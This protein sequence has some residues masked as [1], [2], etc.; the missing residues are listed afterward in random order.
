MLCSSFR[1]RCKCKYLF[2]GMFLRFTRQ[3]NCS[4]RWDWNVPRTNTGR[5]TLDFTVVARTQTF[6][7][8]VLVSDKTVVHAAAFQR[9]IE[10]TKLEFS[11]SQLGL[12]FTYSHLLINLR[13]EFSTQYCEVHVEW[14]YTY[15]IAIFHC[16][17]S[18]SIKANSTYTR[19]I[20]FMCL[21]RSLRWKAT[22]TDFRF[23]T[24]QRVGGIPQQMA[25][26]NETFC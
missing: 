8:Q 20:A 17:C 24:I 11:I 18:K 4:P 15:C 2:I 21:M 19:W 1:R 26:A 16:E 3:L 6:F 14:D 23:N 13:S 9:A 22:Y 5:I 25:C 12:D 7:Y 10:L